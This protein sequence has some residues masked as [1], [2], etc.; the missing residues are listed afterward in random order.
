MIVLPPTALTRMSMLPSSRTIEATVRSTCAGSSALQSLP[1]ARAPAS[2]NSRTVRSSRSSLLS[3]ATTIPPSR[4][5]MS[6]VA[7]PMPLAAA[8]ISATLS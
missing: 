6:A 3:T 8:V 7:R 2:R 4:A 5:M 1:Y